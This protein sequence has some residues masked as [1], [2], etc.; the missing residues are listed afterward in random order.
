ME[1]GGVLSLGPFSC[2]SIDLVHFCFGVG[3][4]FFLF[5]GGGATLFD[6]AEKWRMQEHNGE[7]CEMK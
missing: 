7:G 4:F 1:G 2:G 5:G 6:L 3:M